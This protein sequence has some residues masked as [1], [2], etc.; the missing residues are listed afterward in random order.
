MRGFRAEMAASISKV[1]H[2][3]NVGHSGFDFF[4]FFGGV[5]ARRE[6]HFSS[7]IKGLGL[8]NPL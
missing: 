6:G 2:A 3:P 7:N 4:S 1:S 5:V 8:S